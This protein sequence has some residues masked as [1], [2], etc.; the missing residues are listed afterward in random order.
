MKETQ[1]E[2]QM[3]LAYDTPGDVGQ[4]FSEYTNML[5]EGNASIFEKCDFYV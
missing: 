3:I 5:I 2:L 4:L 1:D